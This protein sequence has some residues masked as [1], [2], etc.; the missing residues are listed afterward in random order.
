M[1]LRAI[2]SMRTFIIIWFGQVVSLLGSGLTNF[3]LGVWVYQRTD[4]VTQF[5]LISL[6]ISLPL[7]LISPVAGAVVDRWNRRWIMI[8]GDSG[9]GLS[10]LVVAL[11]FATGRLEIW[12]IYLTTAF[13]STF[14]A[15]QRPAYT[16]AI[17]QLVPKQHLGR[18]G[19]MT[20]LGEALAQLV[21]PVLAGFLLVT[22]QLQGIILIDF[23]T[24]LFALV[25]LLSIR[26]PELKATEN[27]QKDLL[28]E[29]LAG[30]TYLSARPGLIG[31]LIMFTNSNFLVGV[32]SVLVTPLVLSIASAAVLGTVMS[33]GGLG[34]VAGSVVVSTWGGPKR[35]MNS[36]YSFELL[37][38]LSILATGLR[39]SIPLYGLA[40]FLF[41]FGLPI[42]RVA[43][44]VI[45]QKKVAPNTQGRVFA[46]TGALVTA[47]Q[48]L[49]YLIAGP[50]ADRVFEP[51]MAANGPLAG[52]L[53]QIIGVGPGRGISLMFIVIGFLYLV[54]TLIAYQYRRLRFVE[55][56]L[57]DAIAQ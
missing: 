32:V 25:T 56:E 53:G 41:F 12:H 7:I 37:T 46:L 2:Y 20:Q 31:L 29:A 18:A 26:F 40:A 15:F 30:W 9:A 14:S 45:F 57:P 34:M 10:T 38:G 5:A 48:P 43:S 39:P 22:I 11:L 24:F 4:S 13:S 49:A 51:L 3:A 54:A 36:I 1:A 28:Q 6:F 21:A 16:S 52:S 17:T 50:L 55:D 27:K 19:G 42:V 44:Q 33:I 35:Q 47:T 8:L 23:V